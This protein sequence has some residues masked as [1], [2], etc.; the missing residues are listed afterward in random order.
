MCLMGCSISSQSRMRQSTPSRRKLP[1]RTPS[2]HGGADVASAELTDAGEVDMMNGKRANGFSGS[3]GHDRPFPPP[4]DFS[5][6]SIRDLLEA[7]E[8]YH[9]HLSSIDSVVGTAIG[10]YRIHQKDWY[11]THPPSVPRG[12]KKI[13]QSRTF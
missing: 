11:A 2:A 6:L 3:P 8:H 13:D 9:V 5:S 7:R 10:R 1:C 4:R 12:D